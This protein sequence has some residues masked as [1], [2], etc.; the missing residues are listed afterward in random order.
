MIGDC[1]L[2]IEWIIRWD[3]RALFGQ[4][5]GPTDMYMR[6]QMDIQEVKMVKVGWSRNMFLVYNILAS[7][8][9]SVIR[10]YCSV[11]TF[12]GLIDACN[13]CYKLYQLN[14]EIQ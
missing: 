14:K 4:V 11:F 7:D 5:I 13:V 8:R 10:C 1:I 3:E 9:H 12:Q 2:G 6:W